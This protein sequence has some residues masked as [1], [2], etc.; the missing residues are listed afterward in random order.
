MRSSPTNGNE[1]FLEQM[2]GVAIKQSTGPTPN[3]SLYQS[4][5]SATVIQRG[6]RLQPVKRIMRA[7]Q[8]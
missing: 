6:V 1:S 7:K 4:L 5:K 2:T 3:I 8:E